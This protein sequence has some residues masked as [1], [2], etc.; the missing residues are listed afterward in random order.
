MPM[1][2][3]A[4]RELWKHRLAGPVGSAGPSSWS[5][6]AV[7]GVAGRI[8]LSWAVRGKGNV[9]PALLRKRDAV[10]VECRPERAVPAVAGGAGQPA[11]GKECAVPERKTLKV[12][13]IVERKPR[14]ARAAAV[15]PDSDR[16]MIPVSVP[17]GTPSFPMEESVD[18][19]VWSPSSESV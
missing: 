16:A 14:S 17:M 13:V 7:A 19:A 5:A 10:P 3:R 1:R 9:W 8:G 11:W 6:P 18:C 4:R 2:E 12:V 15:G